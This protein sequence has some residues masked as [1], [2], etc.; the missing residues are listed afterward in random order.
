MEP[1][2]QNGQQG[3]ADKRLEP[4]IGISLVIF[5]VALLVLS[6]AIAYSLVR[7]TDKTAP[8]ISASAV[9]RASSPLPSA[10]AAHAAVPTQQPAT[11][12]A[13]P[14]ISTPAPGVAEPTAPV[15]AAT[16]PATQANPATC[17]LGVVVD[18]P[19]LNIRAAPTQ[20]AAVL[21]AV[22]QFDAVDLLCVD[23][24]QA[25]GR[26]WLRVRYAGVEGWMSDRFLD[27]QE[28]PGEGG[29]VALPT[30]SA[31]GATPASAP[32]EPAPAFV[33]VF[34]IRG[35][36]YSYEAYHHDY[37]AADIFA[38]AGSEFV[39]PTSG[40]VDFVNRE[41]HWAPASDVAA[42]RGGVMLAIV[43]D[44][45]VRYYGSHLLSIADGIEAGARVAAGQLLGLTGASGNAASTPPHLHFGIS[46]P[47]TPDDWQT[48]RGEL[49]PYTY[50]RAWERGEMLTPDL[51]QLGP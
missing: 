23:P 31:P 7:R 46:R 9:P 24:V 39:A 49:P 32:P 36:R 48:R 14:A 16:A 28:R 42:D 1:T 50:L 3:R 21:A 6:V 17:G 40:Y 12:V 47:T 30:A 33:Y 37:P 41:D 4:Y 5:S 11:A 27:V 45:G 20:Q 51:G 35:A 25:E 34:P 15:M 13:T 22:A 18:V 2:E 29:R 43:G 19:A 38:P 44:D 26:V 8:P 10:P